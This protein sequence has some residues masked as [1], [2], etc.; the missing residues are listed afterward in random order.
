MHII[1]QMTSFLRANTSLETD[2]ISTETQSLQL[3]NKQGTRMEKH[4]RKINK[5][6]LQ[7]ENLLDRQTENTH[8]PWLQPEA[9]LKAPFLFIFRSIF[10]RH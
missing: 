1:Q 2:T 4:Q 6:I 8:S 5:I 3:L 9:E 10:S 7:R